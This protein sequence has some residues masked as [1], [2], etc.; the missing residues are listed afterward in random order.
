MTLNRL[1]ATHAIRTGQLDGQPARRPMTTTIIIIIII[2]NNNN[3]IKSYRLSC[4]VVANEQNQSRWCTRVTELLERTLQA[5]IS[6]ARLTG[7][8]DSGA[9]AAARSVQLT[10]AGRASP[11]A[12][13][14]QRAR[15][16]KR[17]LLKMATTSGSLVARLCAMLPVRW[18]AKR[19]IN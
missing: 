1:M 14:E 6:F 4:R 7:D 13:H 15:E 2:T 17:P 11:K 10:S 16:E 9:D 18:L 19:I 3:D 12:I 8:A 5:S